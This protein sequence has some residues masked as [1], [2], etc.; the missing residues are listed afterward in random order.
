LLSL[1]Q[2]EE[3]D[4]LSLNQVSRKVLRNTQ[5]LDMLVDDELYWLKISHENW[6]QKGDLSTD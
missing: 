6:L 5:L 1:E 3:S 4:I 2:A